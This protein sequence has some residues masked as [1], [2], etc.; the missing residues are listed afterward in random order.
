MNTCEVTDFMY[1]MKA[2]LYYATMKQSEYGQPKKTWIFDRSIV[3]NATPL[4]GASK[5]EI[6]PEIFLQNNGQLI[7]RTKTD[8]RT[9]SQESNSAITNI[10]VTNIRNAS[11]VVIYRETAGPRSGRATI[12]EFATVE[13]F[14]G[15][16]GDIQYYKIL[17]RRAE[18][19]SVGD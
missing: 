16:F 3:C 17:W 15:P 9:S 11:D 8:P 1:P 13:P 12:Y 2:D 7:A 10:L 14:V 18:N 6:K 4:G 5:E 19:Q